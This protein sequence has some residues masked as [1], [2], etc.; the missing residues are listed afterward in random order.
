MTLQLENETRHHA[1]TGVFAP[2]T[3]ERNTILIANRLREFLHFAT[4]DCGGSIL[5]GVEY[6]AQTERWVGAMSAA[7]SKVTF[8][9]GIGRRVVRELREAAGVTTQSL[10]D[11][12]RDDLGLTMFDSIFA[13][14]EKSC[15]I[16]MERNAAGA[17]P[18][19]FAHGEIEQ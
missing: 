19:F 3:N 1:L 4:R 18:E 8:P 15:K 2:M 17:R 13:E 7:T 9:P 16:A 5:F 14:I 11:Q 6:D 12:M 10:T